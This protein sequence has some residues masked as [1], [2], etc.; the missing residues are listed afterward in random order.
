MD[1]SDEAV[2]ETGQAPPDRPGGGSVAESRGGLVWE[3]D[4]GAKP[5]TSRPKAAPRPPRWAVQGKA[6]YGR[7]VKRNL[8]QKTQP[9]AMTPKRIANFKAKQQETLDLFRRCQQ[10]GTW[11]KL[12]RAHFDWWMFPIDDGSKQDFNVNSEADVEALRGNEEWLQGYFEGVRL[13]CAAWGWD[14]DSACRIDPLAPGMGYTGWDV[15]L[16]KICRSLYLFEQESLL[17]SM[18]KFARE[19]QRHEKGGANFFYGTICLDELLYFELPRRNEPA[20]PADVPE[21]ADQN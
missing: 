8:P 16:A 5:A 6:S 3:V 12:H 17:S 9:P 21:T 20:A 19:V 11:E 13:V 15:R 14:V 18:Q 4:T 10:A 1:A 7:G 2:T